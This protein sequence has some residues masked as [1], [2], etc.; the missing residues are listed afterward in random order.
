MF[1][2]GGG[3]QE[4]KEKYNPHHWLVPASPTQGHF[5][6]IPR[7]WWT[8]G[9]EQTCSSTILL[10]PLNWW[11]ESCVHHWYLLS[12]RSRPG[13]GNQGPSDRWGRSMPQVVQ[14]VAASS[15]W[16]FHPWGFRGLSPSGPA[17]CPRVKTGWDGLISTALLVLMALEEFPVWLE[18]KELRLGLG[19]G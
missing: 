11:G 7:A 13:C 8:W 1:K 17:W 10:M 4:E 6:Y 2:R 19:N 16:S 3:V 9:L 15:Y 5:V 12:S 14:L 18:Y